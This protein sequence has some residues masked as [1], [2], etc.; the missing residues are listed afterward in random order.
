MKKRD[1]DPTEWRQFTEAFSRQHEGWLVSVYAER[2]SGDRDYLLRDV[3]F[4]GIAAEIDGEREAVVVMVD[5][6]S[7][8]H[9]SHTITKPSRI[10]VT[11][12]DEGAEA[13]VAVTDESGAVI[14]VEFRSP[15]PISAVDGIVKASFQAARSRT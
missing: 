13:A 10:V 11:E 6:S 3:P 15:M 4:R 8:R 1:I 5:G 14:T 9:L 2:R 12:T 7:D